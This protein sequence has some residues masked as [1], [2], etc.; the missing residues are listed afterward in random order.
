[1]RWR[2]SS[3]SIK[4][5]IWWGEI[6]RVCV[7]DKSFGTEINALRSRVHCPE[8]QH[9]GVFVVVDSKDHHRR[10]IY[11]WWWIMGSGGTQRHTGFA[12]APL[13]SSSNWTYFPKTWT[14]W[15][16]GMI[17]MFI[18][19]GWIINYRCSNNNWPHDSELAELD[20]V[21][22]TQFKYFANLCTNSL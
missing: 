13:A 8:T 12:F 15:T 9:Q 17:T 22:Q 4:S 5:I 1:M 21:C 19:F 6:N 20:V 10:K 11:H 7:L 2:F 3:Y 16:S 14:D 18:V